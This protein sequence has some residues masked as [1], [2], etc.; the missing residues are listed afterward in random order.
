MRSF[1]DTRRRV[2]ELLLRGL[3]SAEVLVRG[4]RA[5]RWHLRR[6][7][8]AEGLKPAHCEHC[9]LDTWR[10][11]P[12]SLQLHHVNG[13]GADNRLENLEVLCPNCHSQTDTWGGRNRRGELAA[14]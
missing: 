10:G 14:A 5:N 7:L 2:A 11:R 12:L 4:R 3:T 6:R 1:V 9:L 13:D 8:V